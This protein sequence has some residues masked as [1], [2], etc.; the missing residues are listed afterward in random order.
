MDFKSLPIDHHMDMGS[1]PPD[2]LTADW[3]FDHLFTIDGIK[4]AAVK[5][6]QHVYQECTT[7]SLQ[8]SFKI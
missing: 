1:W 6:L 8:W 2:K 7:Y 4:E 3:Q 5:P